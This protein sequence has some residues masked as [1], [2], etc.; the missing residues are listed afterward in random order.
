MVVAQLIGNSFL[1]RLFGPK[2]AF[3]D[4]CG[5][6]IERLSLAEVRDERGRR[7][8]QRLSGGAERERARQRE[9]DRERE[10]ETGG[11]PETEKRD[12]RPQVCEIP[13]ERLGP[14]LFRCCRR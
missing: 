5:A 4:K 14:C 10:T 11:D 2:R 6:G 12:V 9:R 1:G 7:R 3:K 13:G 8:R